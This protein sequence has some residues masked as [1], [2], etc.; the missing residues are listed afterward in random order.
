MLSLIRSHFCDTSQQ[1]YTE[2]VDLRRGCPFFIFIPDEIILTIFKDLEIATLI[3]LNLTNRRFNKIT[4]S[5]ILWEPIVRCLHL[6]CSKK[7]KD[8]Y[9]KNFS[10]HCIRI[11]KIASKE[12]DLLYVREA[13]KN[14]NSTNDIDHLSKC[15]RSRDKLILWKEFAIH[16][17]EESQIYT[18]KTDINKSKEFGNWI[19][20]HNLTL[21][22][23]QKMR[24][25][26][27][28]LSSIPVELC[29]FQSLTSLNLSKNY[30]EKL[31]RQLGLLTNL[32]TLK[33][34][35][36]RIKRLPTSIIMMEKLKKL[37]L[38]NNELES[39]SKISFLTNLKELN[40]SNNRLMKLPP[41]LKHCIHLK[42]LAVSNNNL[43]ELPACISSFSRLE[44]LTV[45]VDQL[46]MPLKE[47]AQNLKISIKIEKSEMNSKVVVE[48]IKI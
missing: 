36:N 40:L 27:F 11:K 10:N 22:P 24:F 30:I 16:I 17:G 4:N 34:S 46:S 45:T 37:K 18:K 15:L 21:Y 32:T 44:K 41:T 1:N 47:I 35:K 48:D 31:P 43:I 14:L 9:K 38:S 7:N 5:N 8:S 12:K 28:Q 29:L 23:F 26:N 42:K 20:F 39:I 3:S 2:I 6:H 13:L 33:L 25:S 19:A